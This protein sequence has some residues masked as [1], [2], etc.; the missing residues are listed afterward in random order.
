MIT[1]LTNIYTNSRYPF[2]ST[3]YVPNVNEMIDMMT[4]PEEIKEQIIVEYR[5]FVRLQRLLRELQNQAGSTSD[6]EELDD[7]NSEFD[8][9]TESFENIFAEIGGPIPPSRS[10]IYHQWGIEGRRCNYD[11]S[12]AELSDAPK[13]T[14]L[15]AEQN[16]LT[17]RGQIDQKLQNNIEKLRE[18]IKS[19]ISDLLKLRQ[20]LDQV[21]PIFSSV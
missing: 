20:R 5:N 2:N 7:Q 16:G 14:T 18:K 8:I 9:E 10:L 12:Q 17:P 13:D 3:E 21:G 19:Q 4:N 11:P 1:A 15:P 6:H